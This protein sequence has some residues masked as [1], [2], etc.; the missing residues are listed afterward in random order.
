MPWMLGGTPVTMEVLLTLVKLGICAR[1]RPRY[2]CRPMRWRF[3]MRPRASAAS[4]YSSDE[5]SMQMPTIGLGGNSYRRSLTI[6]EAT[7]LFIQILQEEEPAVILF[8]ARAEP[9]IHY[10]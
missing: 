4:K 1:A 2:P 7:V 5:P 8:C 10:K 3:G 6:K 9:G